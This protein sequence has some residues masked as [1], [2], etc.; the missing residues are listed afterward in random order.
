MDQTVRRM[1]SGNLRKPLIIFLE[2]PDG[3]GKTT[4]R[5]I[6][7]ET[8]IFIV[9]RSP[10]SILVYGEFLGRVPDVKY[11]YRLERK[12]DENFTV[13]PIYLNCSVEVLKRRM[14]TVNKRIRPRDLPRI[15][16]LFEKY[17]KKSTWSWI[18]IETTNKSP[19]EIAEPI[20]KMLKFWW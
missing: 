7:Q 11:V 2:G 18:I 14:N 10:L 12:F 15:I 1:S 8:G 6:L 13:V 19:Y 16:K 9:E 4:L 20:R 5:R 17:L 3:S